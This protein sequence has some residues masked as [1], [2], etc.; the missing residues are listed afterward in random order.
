MSSSGSRI[1]AAIRRVVDGRHLDREE[2]HEVFGEMMDGK[3]TDVP[4]GLSEP[5]IDVDV[6]ADGDL[7]GAA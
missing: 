1:A 4:N 3:A 5:M 2:M 6:D 7:R